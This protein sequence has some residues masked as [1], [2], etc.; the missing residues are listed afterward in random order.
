MQWPQKSTNCSCNMSAFSDFCQQVSSYWSCH[1]CCN[2]SLKTG[3]PRA[4]INSYAND[5]S[6]SKNNLHLCSR[7][8]PWVL[9]SYSRKVPQN[10]FSGPRIPHH[11]LRWDGTSAT[12]VEGDQQQL[13]VVPMGKAYVICK[14]Y[15]MTH[16]RTSNY[17][18][19][20]L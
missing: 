7:Q 9:C 12:A 11:P 16:K 1:E 5:F 6:L 3:D 17:K 15:S 2:C 19:P 8:E 18:S 10:I 13:S 20:R 14:V 4:R